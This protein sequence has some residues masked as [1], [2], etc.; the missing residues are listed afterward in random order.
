MSGKVLACVAVCAAGL[1]CTPAMGWQSDKGAVGVEKVEAEFQQ[2][3]DR[4]AVSAPVPR[5]LSTAETRSKAA[6][7]ASLNS[8]SAPAADPELSSGDEHIVVTDP[9]DQ[10]E[11]GL[12]PARGEGDYLLM[13]AS[14]VLGGAV[15]AIFTAFWGSRERRLVAE[16]IAALELSRKEVDRKIEQLTFQQGTVRGAS[17]LPW[18]SE[19]EA[20]HT[21]AESAPFRGVEERSSGDAPRERAITESR[22]PRRVAI[23]DL[24]SGYARVASGQIT[25]AT[26]QSF[27]DSIGNSGPVEVADQGR[28]IVSSRTSE[29]FLTSVNAGSAIVV[30]P[31][32]DFIAN[33]ATQF[34]T[35]ASVPE[36]VS[37]L[38]E[39]KRGDGDIAME[40]PAIFNATDSGPEL[41]SKGVLRGF[42]G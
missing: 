22:S 26:F 34:S 10:N 2:D 41:R 14:G 9:E 4:S 37:L 25:R 15:F 28:S 32:Y 38:F 31:S 12:P 18:P 3:V 40:R 17:P 7:Q 8:R 33:Q 5:N 24:V 6:S 20:G 13:L 27:F 23:G 1:A 30:F 11:G 39:L 16:R 29:A 21:V 42:G 35:I 36:A 19:A